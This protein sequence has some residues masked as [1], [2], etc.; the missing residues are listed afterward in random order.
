M[1]RNTLGFLI[2]F[3]YNNMNFE[4]YI[5]LYFNSKLSFLLKF[6]VLLSLA[7]LINLQLLFVQQN[8]ENYYN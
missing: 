3:Y 8:A 4:F 7:L 2:I 1:M 6:L 5:F